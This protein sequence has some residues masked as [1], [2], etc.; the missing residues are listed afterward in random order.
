MLFVTLLI[1]GII[2]YSKS[3]EKWIT[4]LLIGMSIA[5]FIIALVII[6]KTNRD[7]SPI[8]TEKKK[9]KH[10]NNKARKPFV[11]D[12]KWKELENEDDEMDFIDQIVEDD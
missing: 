7:G 8:K 4:F 2:L 3:S 12:S 5:F 9:K 11:N 10:K 1:I 6:P